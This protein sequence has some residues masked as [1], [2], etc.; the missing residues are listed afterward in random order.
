MSEKNTL[1]VLIPNRS[2]GHRGFFILMALIGCISF[3]AGVV[4]ISVGA[5]PVVGFFGLDVLLIYWAFKLNYRSGM[6]REII[7]LDEKTLIITRITPAG[8]ST[9][10]RFDRYW[11]RVEHNVDAEEEFDNQPLILTSHGRVLEIAS[12]LS[13]DQKIEFTK[14]LRKALKTG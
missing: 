12:F 5:W 13:S 14:F 4:F 9:S 7:E 6:Q 8:R 2:L 3:I 1:A 10:W 11:V